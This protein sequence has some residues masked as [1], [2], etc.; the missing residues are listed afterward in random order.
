MKESDEI[1][2]RDSGYQSAVVVIILCIQNDFHSG[3]LKLF[4]GNSHQGVKLRIIYFSQTDINI[5]RVTILFSIHSPSIYTPESSS[6]EPLWCLRF[7]HLIL[8]RY[9]ISKLKF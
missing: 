5:R 2:R 8:P 4:E 7:L 6:D 1:L 9:F 3:I